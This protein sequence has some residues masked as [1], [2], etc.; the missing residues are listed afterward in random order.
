MVKA[1]GKTELDPQALD[2]E[3]ELPAA[4]GAAESEQHS[5][6]APAP[7]VEDLKQEV[8]QLKSERDSLLARLQAEFN[9]A[10]KRQAREQQEFREYALADALKSLLPALDSFDHA[11]AADS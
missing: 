8:E 10:R 2:V 6:T 7:S 11:L 3:H 1:N 9:N 5:A 4:E